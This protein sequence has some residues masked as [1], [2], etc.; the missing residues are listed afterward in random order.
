MLL[1]K[2]CVPHLF[3]HLTLYKQMCVKFEVLHDYSVFLYLCLMLCMSLLLIIMAMI[4]TIG[5]AVCDYNSKLF[6][7]FTLCWYNFEKYSQDV[8]KW[9]ISE[10][11]IDIEFRFLILFM[12]A[13]LGKVKWARLSLSLSVQNPDFSWCEGKF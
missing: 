1:F 12:W 2:N 6:L 13:S 11:Q 9:V 3:F 4:I 8:C 10:L 7:L 5:I